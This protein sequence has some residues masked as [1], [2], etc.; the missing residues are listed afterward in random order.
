MTAPEVVKSYPMSKSQSDPLGRLKQLA[1]I[2]RAITT[3]LDFD[4]VLR[5]IVVSAVELVSADLCLLLLADNHGQ[6]RIRAR[7]G[8]YRLDDAATRRFTAPMQEAAIDQLRELVGLTPDDALA[9]AP[10]I[11]KQ[12]VRGLLVVVP[13]RTLDAEGEWLLA[14]LADQ[15]AIALSNAR[16]HELEVALLERQRDESREELREREQQ[17]QFALTAVGMGTWQWDVATDK[18]YWNATQAALFGFAQQ[19]TSI[20][21][22]EFYAHIHP[23]D[24]P[25]VN[26][27]VAEMLARKSEF[28]AEFRILRPDGQ[29][30]WLAGRGGAVWNEA[31]QPLQVLGINFDIT[32]SKQAEAELRASEEFNRTVIE[33]SPD[34]VK[35]LDLE[36]RLLVMSEHGR[37][38]MEIDDFT[39]L[40]GQHWWSLWPQE[41]QG[42]V[43]E[44]FE[45][46]RKGGTGH[47]QGFCPTAKGTPKWWDVMVTPVP[48]VDNQ[49]L[50]LV[51]TSR[52]ITTDKQAQLEREQL[53]AREHEARQ[54]AETANR[55][56]DEFLATLSHELRNPLNAIVGSAEIILGNREA[57]QSPTIKPAA[58]IIYRSAQAQA[59]LVSDLLDLSRLQTGKLAL[60][61]QAL[62]IAPVINDAIETVRADADAKGIKL[63]VDLS[64]EPLLI[65]ADPVRVQQIVWNLLNNAVKFTPDGGHVHISLQSNGKHARLAVTDDG[66]GIEPGFLPHVFEMFRQAD[67]STTR[68]HGGMGIG[69]ALVRQLTELHGGTIAASSDGVG[70]GA[71]FTVHLPLHT[72]RRAARPRAATK[73]AATLSGLHLLVVDDALE[74]ADMMRVLLQ[75]NGATV[76]AVT[77]GS[78]ALEIALA[79]DFDLIL[80]DISMPEMDGYELLRHLR[81]HPKTADVPA[82]ALT[83]FGQSEDIKQAYDAGFVSHLTK[84]I[85][86]SELIKVARAAALSGRR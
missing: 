24:L 4:E 70:R 28:E 1:A 44:A 19:P 74:T 37:C 18:V 15:A 29:V 34:C 62:A 61:R 60:H 22:D 68:R 64:D 43:R 6:L 16:L 32:E 5:R 33:N 50:R 2:N 86:L 78:K 14:T 35:V 59:Q 26:R 25:E 46:A 81:A 77:S 79:Q 21:A 40:R 36:G 20:T 9:A 65:E 63:A 58:H 49:P 69:L 12:A 84:P 10:V 31:G 76:E 13:R 41:T 85:N 55:L 42:R 57:Q 39:P 72:A 71:S 23:D 83:G 8:A 82:I 80:S 75:M 51:S 7:A 56:K 47:F 27:R 73:G 30:R 17:L 52:D 38:L 3:S 66:Q 48:G 53:L 45:Q 54:Q 67:A 11:S